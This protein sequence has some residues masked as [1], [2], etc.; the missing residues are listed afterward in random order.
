MVCVNDILTSQGFSDYTPTVTFLEDGRHARLEHA[1]YYRDKKGDL[2]VAWKGMI[3][4]GASIPR[5]F[6]RLIGSPFTGK[7]RVAAIIH[8]AECKQVW[9]LAADLFRLAREQIDATF[10]EMMAHLGVSKYKR[11][12]MYRAVRAA[13]RAVWLKKCLLG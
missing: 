10:L 7:Y 12:A 2:H 4:D 3:F 8:D 11:W 1:L 13:S 6:W 9:H 5:L